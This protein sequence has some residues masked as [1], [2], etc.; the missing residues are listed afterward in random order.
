ML[1]K[2]S[3]YMTKVSNFLIMLA[4]IAGMVGCNGNGD[5]SESYTL[6]ID[7]T[8]GG[9]VTA[10]G[11]GLFTYYEGRVVKLVAQAEEGYRFIEWTGDMDSVADIRDASTTITM[12]VDYVITA[13]FASEIPENLEI[14]DWYDLDAVRNNLAGNHTLMNDLNSTT[15]GYEEMASPTAHYGRGWQPIGT[16]DNPFYGTFEGQGYEIYGLFINR[17]HEEFV[18]LFG[19]VISGVIKDM[20]VVNAAVTGGCNVGGLVGSSHGTVSNSYSSGNVSGI[21][22]SV[23]GLVGHNGGTLSNSY[24]A[25][26]VAS[27]NNVG[28]LVGENDG[29]VSNSRSSGN[30]TASDNVVGGL[31]GQNTGTVSNSYSTASVIGTSSVGGLVGVNAAGAGIVSKSYSTGSVTGTSSIGG[32][33]GANNNG[34]VSD[35]FWDTET[36]GQATSDGGTGKNTTEM[37][38]ITTFLGVAWDIVAVALNETNPAYIWNIVDNVT[39][40]FLSWQA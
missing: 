18:G 27:D 38:D 1:G 26:S 30:V 21:S 23:G 22:S 13:N 28:G 29:T 35:S 8:A 4:L 24:S 9:S 14:W 6:A 2:L 11:E 39:Y 25:A 36:S 5:G 7:S 31:A 16:D 40:P 15:P 3:C 10:P 34:S 37:Q 19:Y 17:L 32:L 12:N 20:G 33:V